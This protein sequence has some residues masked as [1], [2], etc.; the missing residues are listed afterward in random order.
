MCAAGTRWSCLAAAAWQTAELRCSTSPLL[1]LRTTRETR[2]RR[3]RRALRAGMHVVAHSTCHLNFI[4][5][6]N[7]AF[8]FSKI[9]QSF[10]FARNHN[11][12]SHTSHQIPNTLNCTACVSTHDITTLSSIFSPIF[13]ILARD[14]SITTRS[15]NCLLDTP[16]STLSLPPASLYDGHIGIPSENRDASRIFLAYLF[17]TRMELERTLNQPQ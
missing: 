4:R 9:G 15:A 10:M 2:H 14:D 12:T 8:H 11:Q 7:L 1:H 6:F 16:I 17:L 5:L 13:E 3:D